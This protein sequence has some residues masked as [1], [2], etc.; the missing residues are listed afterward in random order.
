MVSTPSDPG[1][2][3]SDRPGPGVPPGNDDHAA[4]RREDELTVVDPVNPTYQRASAKGPALIVLG[5]AVFIVVVGVVGSILV[6]SGG[7]STSS[8]RSITLPGG[9]VVPLVPATTALKSI[10]SAGQP[11]ADIIG[12]LAVPSDSPVTH[13]VDSDDGVSQ[14]DRTVSFTSGMTSD[15]VVSLY[16]ALLPKLGW[17]VIFHGAGASTQSQD[18]EVLAKKASTDSFYWEVGVVVS[19]TTTAG[20]TPFSLEVFQVS[21]D[22]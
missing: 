10:V 14:F 21:D 7:G 18:T 16:R 5:I 9:S 3:R 20:T 8:L 22:N 1:T 15:E 19:P 6:T 2:L 13:T 11:P 17:Q 4:Y 12:A